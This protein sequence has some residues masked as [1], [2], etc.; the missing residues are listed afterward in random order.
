MSEKAVKLDPYTTAWVE[1]R[2]DTLGKP[3]NHEIL[4]THLIYIKFNIKKENL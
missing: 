2:R 4:T 3:L 1:Y